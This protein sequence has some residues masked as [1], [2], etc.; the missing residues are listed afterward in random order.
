MGAAP[1]QL[2]RLE[3][4]CARLEAVARKLGGKKGGDDEGEGPSEGTLAFQAF[5]KNEVQAFV[6][7]CKGLPYPEKQKN[8]G[9]II[10]ACFGNMV[11]YIAKADVCKKPNDADVPKALQVVVD[12]IAETDKLKFTRKALRD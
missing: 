4:V 1:A 3:A 9:D 6:D 7:A 11:E 10:A 2:D 12:S 8:P 5:Q